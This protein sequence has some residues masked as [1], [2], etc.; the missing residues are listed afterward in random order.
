MN[1][2]RNLLASILG[3]ILAIGILF[4]FFLLIM[5]GAA[6]G[7]EPV[8]RVKDNSILQISLQRPI[9]DY[10]GQFRINDL[11][12]EFEEYMGLNHIIRAIDHA[13]EDSKI[14][15]I[16]IVNPMIQSGSATTQA[17]RKALDRFK[18]S[19]KFVYAYAELYSQKDY[20]LASVA[21]SVYLNPQGIFDFRGLS[22]EV[23]FFGDFQDKSGLRMEVIRHGKYKSAVEPFL[24]NTMSEENRQQISE[25]L[26]GLW[27][28]YL[29]DISVSRDIPVETLETYADELAA[30]TPEMAVQNGFADRLLYVDEYRGIL[31]EA[32]G[33]DPSDDIETIGMEDYAE[34]AARKRSRDSNR[35]AVVYAQ[36]DIGYGEGSQD[37]IAQGIMYKSLKDARDDDR[38]KAI[39]LRINS[40]GG[41]ALTSDLIWREVAITS[42]QKPV[43]I[44]M[45]NYAASGGYYIA[46]GGD[47]IFAE[48]TTITGSIGVFVT[49]P[50]VRDLAE[51]WG[52]NAEQ[53]TTNRYSTGYSLFEE[54]SEAFRT[55]SKESIERDYEHFLEIVAEARDMSV[56]EVDEV[57]QGRVWTG[58]Q[59]LEK[60]LVDELGSLQDA[61]AYAADQAGV[62]SYTTVD[63]PVYES[64]F[65]DALNDIG[66]GFFNTREEVLKQ[67]LGAEVYDL[68]MRIK[69]LAS[70]KGVQARMPYELKIQ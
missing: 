15:G 5:V 69:H 8:V 22:S 27:G 21:D 10:G 58:T 41:L 23:L 20:W 26:H 9:P 60:G 39:V 24:G 66:I 1:F 12:Y 56:G 18:E 33:A 64:N 38:V 55:Y 61:V 37:M 2:L 62:S 49:I 48:P 32:L 16:S 30:R 57:A 40:P 31:K 68:M 53:V 6:A 70:M 3:T 36:G 63:Y 4:M 34:Y 54:P 67:E 43:I 11:D 45:G 29:K 35:I 14:K 17:I 65:L 13:A 46:A 47:R 42:E 51:K 44:S 28:E 52:I 59:A 50:N 25:L 19:G 7:S